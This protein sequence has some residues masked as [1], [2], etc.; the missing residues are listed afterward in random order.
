MILI[1]YKNNYYT[2]PYKKNC[3]FL[4]IFFSFYHNILVFVSL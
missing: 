4:N 1:P 2:T 3:I